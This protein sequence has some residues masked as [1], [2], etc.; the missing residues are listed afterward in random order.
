MNRFILLKTKA[1]APGNADVRGLSL[2]IIGIIL[3]G[4][5]FW[6]F[7][8]ISDRP[9]PSA[10]QGLN[11]PSKHTQQVR[12]NSDVVPIWNEWPKPQAALMIS[13]EQHGFFE[14]CGCTS[15]QMGGMARRADIWRKLRDSGWEIRGVDLGGL[16]RRTVRQSQIKYETSMQALNDLQYVAVGLGPEDLRLQPDFLITQDAIDDT[17]MAPRLVSANLLFYGSPE[18]GTPVQSRIVDIGERRVGITSIMSKSTIA[19]IVAEG[20]GSDITW[21]DPDPSI[22]N[23]LRDFELQNVDCRILLSHSLPDESR[24]LAERYPQFDAIVVG[25]GFSDPDPTARTEK[26][27]NTLFL[28]I[29]HKGKHIGILGLYPSDHETPIRFQLIPLERSEFR[30]SPAMIVHMRN[31]QQR[32][33]D[34]KIVLADGVIGHPSGASFVGAAKCGECHTEAYSIWETTPHA[35]AFESLDPANERKGHERLNGVGRMYDPECLS[36]H[37]TGWDP[38]EYIRYHGGFLNSEFAETQ[39]DRRLQTLLAGNQCENCH[40]PGSRHIELLDGGNLELAREEM[41]V[42]YEQAESMC[43]DCH[44]TD[45]SPKFDFD[46][47]WPKVEHYGLD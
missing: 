21:S 38:Q 32:L 43:Y 39:E 19:S 17:D 14:P 16:S 10:D 31:Y 22:A 37:V 12:H 13:G 41:K 3:T 11:R 8:Q 40:G 27:G 28:Q 2:I 33:R 4:S 1:S 20:A 30:D 5:L 29:G 6:L 44:D 18:I 36:C 35:H 9:K 42:T 26:I 25:Q 46:E 23:V 15:N 34:E 7:I 47:Y 45:N 24:A